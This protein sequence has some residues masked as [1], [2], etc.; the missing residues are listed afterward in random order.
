VDCCSNAGLID[1]TR[2]IARTK[3]RGRTSTGQL[4]MHAQLSRISTERNGQL[5]AGQMGAEPTVRP[6]PIG[7]GRTGTPDEHY[8]NCPETPDSRACDVIHGSVDRM[9]PRL[10]NHAFFCPPLLSVPHSSPHVSPSTSVP[11]HNFL[12][13]PFLEKDLPGT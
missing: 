5:M 4:F 11:L 12:L 1:R 2:L 8:R 7:P 3:P 6:I 9:T 13:H 10:E